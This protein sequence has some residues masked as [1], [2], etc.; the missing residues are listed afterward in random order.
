[1]HKSIIPNRP[2][3]IVLPESENWYRI[4]LWIEES[5]FYIDDEERTEDEK[6]KYKANGRNVFEYITHILSN[7]WVDNDNDRTEQRK[8]I[9][10]Y[11]QMQL[12]EVF[13]L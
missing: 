12:E 2:P 10:E 5:V 3:D 7:E 11:Y 8:V 9:E 13:E 4:C 1:M 6:S